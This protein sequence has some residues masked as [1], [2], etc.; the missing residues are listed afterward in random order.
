MGQLGDGALEN[1]PLPVEI[2][3]V[4]E[5]LTTPDYEN[6]ISYRI[7]PNPVKDILTLTN[8]MNQ[9]PEMV[10]ISDIYGKVLLEK[11]KNTSPIS[12]SGPHSE[13][14]QIDKKLSK[15]KKL[16]QRMTHR[17]GK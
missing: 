14:A 7:Y 10:V 6:T 13:M 2:I 3:C 1:R 12:L 5:G 11:T 15:L 4:E 9:Q 17:H 16:E 8:N